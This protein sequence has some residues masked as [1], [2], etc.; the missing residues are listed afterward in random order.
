MQGGQWADNPYYDATA[1]KMDGEWKNWNP[2]KIWVPSK[3]GL[4]M[5][6]VIDK[7]NALYPENKI[8]Y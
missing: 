6:F 4:G 3:E 5:R 2:K 8:K 7:F 1:P